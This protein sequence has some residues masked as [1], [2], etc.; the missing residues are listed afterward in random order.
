[1]IYVLAFYCSVLHTGKHFQI[2]LIRDLLL[3]GKAKYNLPPRP[4]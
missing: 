4:N 3:N 2:R 1:L